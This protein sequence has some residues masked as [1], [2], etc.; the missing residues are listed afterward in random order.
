[1]II[2][3]NW[4]VDNL[5]NN[6]GF[7]ALRQGNVEATAILQSI[8]D[9]R[10]NPSPKGDTFGKGA[11]KEGIYSQIYTNAGFYGDE[12]C[13]RKWKNE[14]I[15][16]LMN[17]DCHLDV[18]SCVSFVICGD[19]LTKLNIFSPTLG[20][21]ERIDFWVNLLEIFKKYKK[22]I[23][24]VSYFANEMATQYKNIKNI[25]P[26]V[27]L[28]DINIKF[29]ESWNTIKGNELHKDWNDTFNK[30]KKK[31]DNTDSDIYLV[32]CGCY[33]L[34]LCN[35]IKSKNK[36]SIYVGGLLQMVFGLKGN[37]WYKRL[38][39]NKY[40]NKHWKY[41]TKKPKNAMGVE[42]WCYGNSLSEPP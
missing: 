22:K 21:I 1:M 5:L 31:I 26:H 41:P 18:V 30:L 4:L 42:N 32:S 12:A 3:N 13:Y 8:E 40:Y 2:N 35:Y 29:V 9:A 28:S 19:L 7:M 11:Q 17:M 25:F 24:V 10:K 14:Y 15:R 36:N 38:N 37:R 23:C 27:D 39:M 33:G 16:A 20:Y 6:K 34:P